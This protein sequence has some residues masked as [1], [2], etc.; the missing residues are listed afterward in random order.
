MLLSIGA[1]LGAA[2]LSMLAKLLTS[3]VIEKLV[4]IGLRKLAASTSSK[5]DDEVVA[6]VEAAIAPAPV[7]PKE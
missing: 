6:V 3:A 2:G 7:V 5:V 1:A 4:L